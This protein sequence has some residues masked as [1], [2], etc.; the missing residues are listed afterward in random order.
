MGP[1]C[2]ADCCI[3]GDG[4][5][6]NRAIDLRFRLA[7]LEPDEH[8]D[9]GKI[10]SHCRAEDLSPPLLLDRD[11]IVSTGSGDEESRRRD[12]ERLTALGHVDAV[13]G[14][15]RRFIAV[16]SDVAPGDL[17]D[18]P[19]G[20]R[21]LVLTPG[22]AVAPVEEAQANSVDIG[23]TRVVGLVWIVQ[24][25]QLAIL[26]GVEPIELRR[27]RHGGVRTGEGQAALSHDAPLRRG[28]CLVPYPSI[29]PH[30]S[31]RTPVAAIQDDDRRSNRPA[32]R[33]A[34]ARSLCSPCG[35]D[36]IGIG[37]AS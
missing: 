16:R 32:H 21:D 33:I 30:R 35:A 14:G 19:T 17:G 9:L 1:K 15:E 2:G 27:P 28:S 23:I 6:D 36:L 22:V 5:V 37:S 26:V 11:M 20:C 25:G 8:R 34:R 24:I 3:G 7:A 12:G 13:K 29:V 31:Q 18:E 4:P 10:A